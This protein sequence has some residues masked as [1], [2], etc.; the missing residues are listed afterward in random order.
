MPVHGLIFM[1]VGHI[2]PMHYMRHKRVFGSNNFGVISSYLV[3]PEDEPKPSYLGR[4]AQMTRDNGL[5]YVY[6]WSYTPDV[7]WMI[8]QGEKDRWWTNFREYSWASGI[9]VYM[10]F[11][12]EVRLE[13]NRS[14]DG[15]NWNCGGFYSWRYIRYLLK[16]ARKE[17]VQV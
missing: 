6:P 8:T 3:A 2:I 13:L 9:H 14:N 4:L 11:K 17:G 5:T 15:V 12:N 16:K 10:R 7:G 1:D